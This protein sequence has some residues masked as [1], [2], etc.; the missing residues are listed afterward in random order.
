MKKK[1]FVLINLILC[2]VIILFPK[3]VLALSA[4]LSCSS[5]GSVTIGN[6]ISV[7]IKGSASESAYWQGALSYDSSKLQLV[8]GSINAFTD[9]ATSSPSF[10]YKFKAIATGSAYVKMSGVNVSDQSGNSEI[11]VSS[12]NCNITVANK[13]VET[14]KSADNNLKTLGVDG[15]TLSPEFNKDT[16]EYSVELESDVTKI[17]VYAEKN[18]SK[19]SITGIGEKEV[20]EGTNKIEAVVTAENGSTKTYIINATVKEKDPIKV[21][22]SGKEY[23]IVRKLEGLSLPNSFEETD[24][25]INDETIKGLYNKT[26][27]YTLVA[28][29]N[30]KNK[31]KFYIYNKNKNTYRK[32]TMISSSDLNIIVLDEDVDVPHK[33]SKTTFEYNDETINGYTYGD[34]DFKL[35]YG[36]NSVTGEE[37]FYQIDVKDRVIQR[38][39]N[40][41]TEL[42]VNLTQRCKYAFIILGG[43]ILFLT[44]IILVLLSKN[45][46][47][48][49][50]YLKRK[51]NEIDNPNYSKIKYEDINDELPS[52]E[53]DEE[54]SKK[55]LKKR[56]KQEKKNKK[57]EKT[58][59]DD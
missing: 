56:K 49:K 58:F 23:T 35:V 34:T 41:Q 26:L 38:F 8:S 22:V 12:S 1:V 24:V 2:F 51:L 9:N 27:D 33:Y 11:T 18:D 31:V 10:S 54:L 29:S 52:D 25:E 39:F 45:V 50:M 7:T 19:A 28:L 36:I 15:A 44:I 57:R 32:F 55:E 16:L 13:A 40:A 17:N 53:D 46:K 6:T 4:S 5:S 14:P 48:K 47:F 42:Y 37:G 21:K 3:N 20:Q 30:S 43:F 59:L